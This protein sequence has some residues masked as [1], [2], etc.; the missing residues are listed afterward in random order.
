MCGCSASR[1]VLTSIVG[2]V[3]LLLDDRDG[4]LKA[5]QCIV[6]LA[7]TRL[8]IPSSGSMLQVEK[9]ETTWMHRWFVFK[10]T[11]GSIMPIILPLSQVSFSDS[12]DSYVEVF[13]DSHNRY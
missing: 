12:C 10:N 1:F 11:E 7:A 3:G 5:Y 13:A 6:G 8:Q 4:D 2:S 9:I